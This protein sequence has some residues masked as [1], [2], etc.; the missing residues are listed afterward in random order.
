MKR[1]DSMNTPWIHALGLLGGLALSACDL[2]MKD[3]GDEPDSAG[4]TEGTSETD[5]PGMTSGSGETDG[6]A[7]EPG[8]SKM[9]EDGCNTC[10]CVEDGQWACTRADCGDQCTPGDT[11]PHEDGC[12]TCHCT[13]E[14]DWACTE[15]DCGDTDG[16]VGT[17]G[18]MM[19]DAGAPMDAVSIDAAIVDGDALVLDVSYSGGCETHV[20]AACWD[21][22]F[23]ESLPVQVKLALSHDANDD[24][25]DAYIHEQI[26]LDLTPLAEAHE[27]S[28]GP[29]SA[30]I[31]IN[32]DGWAGGSL[33]YEF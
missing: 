11:V 10:D 8:D 24:V 4:G 23:L 16:P 25:C 28:Y 33:Q 9:H 14:G 21:G 17:D 29:G 3:I 2:P 12:N 7:C 5:G 13:N 1:T 15:I 32:L 27:S 19:C 31:V 20:F 18:V 26:T 22:L 30:T 6:T